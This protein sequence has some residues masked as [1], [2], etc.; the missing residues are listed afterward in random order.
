MLNL[1]PSS[2]Y[3]AR[4]QRRLR[5]ENVIWLTTVDRTGTP[6]SVPVW[7]EWDGERMLIYS[8]PG[9]L[10]VRNI[11]RNPRVNLHFNADIYGDD[12]VVLTGDARTAPE[13]PSVAE[14]TPYVEK[15]RTKMA[16][17][18]MTPEAF[19]ATYSTAILFS[20]ERVSGH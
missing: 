11:E 19:S 9:Q 4:V 6:R 13:A 20:P 8:E 18:G 16:G 2:E 1:D 10:K 15:Y 12:I 3:G 17:I 5:D 7:F 14:N